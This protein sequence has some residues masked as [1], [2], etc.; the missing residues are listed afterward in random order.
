MPALS[1]SVSERSRVAANLGVAFTSRLS[2]RRMCARRR[3]ENVSDRPV[4]CVLQPTSFRRV[5]PK[6]P[7]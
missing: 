3:A 4:E 7:S 1:V 2:D 5:K 6:S